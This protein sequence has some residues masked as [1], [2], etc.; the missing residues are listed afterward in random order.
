MLIILLAS[1]RL[2]VT[3]GRSVVSEVT[4]QRLLAARLVALSVI[5]AAARE[6]EETKPKEGRGLG[7]GRR[8]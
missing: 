3:R 1:F 5:L 4:T 6:E 8:K 2:P 7:S